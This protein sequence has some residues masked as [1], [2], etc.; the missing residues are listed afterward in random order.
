MVKIVSLFLDMFH[1]RKKGLS[2]STEWT[3]VF[4]LLA[5]FFSVNEVDVSAIF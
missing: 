2:L 5:V 1:K 3:T 4:P